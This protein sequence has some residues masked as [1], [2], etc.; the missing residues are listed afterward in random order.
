M[1]VQSRGQIPER[2]PVNDSWHRQTANQRTIDAHFDRH[3]PF[4]NEVY[5]RPELVTWLFKRRLE[6][7][8]SWVD[9]LDLAA[10]AR[11]LDAGCGAGQASIELARRGF[12]VESIDSVPAMVE[13]ARTNATAAGLVNPPLV[14]LGDVHAVDAEPDHYDL[15]LA[16]GVIPWLH[17]PAQALREVAR[18]L[19]PGGYVIVSCDNRHGVAVLLD[20][21]RTP[22]L[23]PVRRTVATALRRLRLRQVPSHDPRSQHHRRRELDAMIRQAGLRKLAARTHGFGPFSMFNRSL[24]DSLGF[25]LLR[26]LQ[27]LA[28]RGVPGLRSA[29]AS[30]MVLAT[31][32]EPDTSPRI[33]PTAEV[34]PG[35]RVGER[36][37]IWNEAQVR[38][39]AQVGTDCILAKG[40]YIDTGVVVGNRVKLENRVSVFQG[41][42]LADGVFIGPHSALLND[43]VPRAIT[44]DGAL[45]SRRDWKANGVRVDEG[46][47]IGG[48]CTL[49]P[50]VRVGRFAMVGAGAVV[51]RSVPDFGLVV[52]SP[53]RLIG[54]VCE[55]GD[56]LSPDG[57]CPTCGRQH[58]LNG[59]NA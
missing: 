46:A 58:E 41:A 45:K 53:A 22:A 52:G 42:Q 36:T 5:G 31:K 3:A 33:H 59:G 17:S 16:L 18:V 9:S 1:T 55:C 23:D 28:D 27:G 13:L 40:V 15:V 21:M 34:S 38:E 49:L 54:F 35:A 7:A 56:R 24:P 11:I 43:K 51:T 48:G 26:Q 25:P 4:W 50:G 12:E 29:G 47:S 30:Y 10:G 2:W 57:S 44:P 6:I 37:R 14:H 39:G 20:P 32:Q 8:L 19:K